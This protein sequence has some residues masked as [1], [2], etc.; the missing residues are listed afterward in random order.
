MAELT[1]EQTNNLLKMLE[2]DLDL[3]V[4]YMDEE[5]R[6]KKTTQLVQYILS[7]SAFIEREGITLD[8]SKIGDCILTVM[9]ASWLYDKRKDGVAIMPRMLR[10]N[11][12]NRLWDEKVKADV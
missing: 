9:Y 12:N 10:Y 2:A 11:L 3:M 5:A 8:F 4:D 1:R 6:Q 7:A